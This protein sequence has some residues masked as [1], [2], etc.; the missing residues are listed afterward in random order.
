MRYSMCLVRMAICVRSRI[1]METQ[2]S[3]SMGRIVPE[4]IFSMQKI[5]QVR[6]L[7]LITTAIWQSLSALRQIREI[8]PLRMMPPVIWLPLPTRMERQVVLVMTAISWSGQKDRIRDVLYMD[9]EPIAVWNVLQRLGRDILMRQV[10]SIQEQ[11][12]KLLIRS[13]EQLFIQSR[14]WMENYHQQQTIKFI[15]GSLIDLVLLLR[16]QTMP[17]MSALSVI[18]MMAPDVISWDSRHWQESL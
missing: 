2:W 15:H 1:H 12:L 4:I 8:L 16:S 7:Y 14:V 5:R 18:M 3:A 11:R 17:V 13:L 10:P 9:T 6:E